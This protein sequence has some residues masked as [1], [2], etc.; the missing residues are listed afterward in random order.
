MNQEPNEK[1]DI[2]DP[3]LEDFF[4]VEEES[5]KDIK[6][7]KRKKRVLKIGITFLTFLLLINVLAI[8]TNVINIPAL[9]F[10]KTSYRL[11]Q[12]D[13]I[14][15]AK[16]AVVTIQGDGY[17]GTGFNIEKDGLIVT[18]SH[19]I[20]NMK[21]IEIYFPNGKVFRGDIVTN[22]PEL[23]IAILEIDGKNLPTLKLQPSRNWTEGEHIYVIGNP[24]SFSQIA[25]EG[26]IEGIGLIADR[27]TPV[28]K[29]SAPV[30]RGNSGSPVLTEKNEV[31]AVVYATTVPKMTA[32]EK[33]S[34]LAVP[35]ENVRQLL[36]LIDKK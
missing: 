35:I 1:N 3:P 16:Q 26:E 8:W 5:E 30:Y 13:T 14:K 10:V 20:E 2:E 6:R 23:D 28:M 27:T 4:L 29:I 19:V 24:L 36:E 7:K 17:K 15:L 33:A 32:D 9:E 11:S 18:N 34:G 31:V 12:R 22:N 21:S 25:N